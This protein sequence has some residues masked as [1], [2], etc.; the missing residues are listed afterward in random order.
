M[1]IPC[2]CLLLCH[3]WRCG[4]RKVRSRQLCQ[5]SASELSPLLKSQA[6]P[7][8]QAFHALGL[9][10]AMTVWQARTGKKL[11]CYVAASSP[12]PQTWSAARRQRRPARGTAQGATHQTAGACAVGSGVSLACAQA[13]TAVAAAAAHIYA[14]AVSEQGMQGRHK[15]RESASLTC[16][17]TVCKM[18]CGREQGG[19]KHTIVFKAWCS[20]LCTGRAAPAT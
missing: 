11:Q 7:A 17:V 14:C 18:G 8:P 4:D 9:L 16:K 1:E 5:C 3:V 6:K 10:P 20:M 13:D 12:P 2:C 19:A 15:L